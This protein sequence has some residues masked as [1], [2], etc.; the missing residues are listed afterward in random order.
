M[1][2]YY[3]VESYL[4]Q[5][6]GCFGLSVASMRGVRVPWGARSRAAPTAAWRTESQSHHTAV[7]I[8]KEALIKLVILLLY[9][10]KL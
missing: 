8:L 7:N 5:F 1:H 4:V 10:R 9:N 6:L 2:L 3:N